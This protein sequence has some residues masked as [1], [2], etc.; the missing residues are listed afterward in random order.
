MVNTSSSIYQFMGLSMMTP[1]SHLDMVLP[2][3][4]SLLFAI[5]AGKQAW[6]VS[7]YP[8]T[9][10]LVFNAIDARQVFFLTGH[11]PVG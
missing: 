9:V 2:P 1:S 7:V 3:T 5:L 10:A 6:E 8:F 11:H 4:Q